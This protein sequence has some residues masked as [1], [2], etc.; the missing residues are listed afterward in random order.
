MK[1]V[2]EKD[3][4][5]PN[6]QGYNR[7]YQ[8]GDVDD[9][10]KCPEYFV[11]LETEDYVVNFLTA[12]ENELLEAQWKFSDAADAV[13][14]AYGINLKKTEKSDIVRQILD[15]KFRSISPADTDHTR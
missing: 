15:A 1:C 4:Y 11:S 3:C 12:S 9:F 5:Q 8:C 6:P 10:E 13:K 2:C 14:E 7:L